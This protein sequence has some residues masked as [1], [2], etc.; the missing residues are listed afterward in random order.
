M[1]PSS[2]PPA[3]ATA[4]PA[5]EGE[6]ATPRRCAAKGAS[7]CDSPGLYAILGLQRL[8]VAYDKGAS[9]NSCFCST[10]AVWAPLVAD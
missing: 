3:S 5:N 8:N 7:V 10:V 2:S 6:A 4:S 1:L 9:A